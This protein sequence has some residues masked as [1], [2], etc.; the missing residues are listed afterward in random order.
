MARASLADAAAAMYRTLHDI[1]LQAEAGK[2]LSLELLT[3]AQNALDVADR[4]KQLRCL[5]YSPSEDDRERASSALE[6]EQLIPASMPGDMRAD[7]R[8]AT[9]PRG[10]SLGK[11]EHIDPSSAPI[12]PQAASQKSLF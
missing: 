9:A 11:D 5:V 1:T 8:N 7:L 3:E 4:I 12:D 6:P 2:P 10:W